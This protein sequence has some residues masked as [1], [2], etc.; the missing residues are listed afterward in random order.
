MLLDKLCFGLRAAALGFPLRIA[1]MQ[2]ICGCIK[3]TAFRAGKGALQ[4]L[5]AALTV[6]GALI[7]IRRCW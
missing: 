1:Y 4:A 3:L 7:P 2:I 6:A 5:G